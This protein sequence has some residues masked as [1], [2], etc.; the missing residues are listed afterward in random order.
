MVLCFALSGCAVADKNMGK[1]GGVAIGAGTGAV[2][3]KELGDDSGMVIGAILGAGVG[4]IIGDYIDKRRAEQK[5]IAQKYDVKINFDDIKYDGKYLG[6]KV[7]STNENQFDVGKSTLN[8]NAKEYYENLAKSYAKNTKETKILI[9]GHTDDSGSS[10]LNKKLSEERAKE[11]G[12]VFSKNGIKSKN[13]YYWGAG[14]SQPIADNNKNAGRMKNRRVEIIE[15]SNQSDIVKYTQNIKVNPAYFTKLKPAVIAKSKPFSK[16]KQRQEPITNKKDN[17][18]QVGD[19]KE[20][21]KKNDTKNITTSPS[22][23]VD[24]GGKATNDT[25]FALGKEYGGRKTGFSLIAKAYASDFMSNCAYDQYHEE[26]NI[27][28]LLSGKT[29]IKTTDQKKGLNGGVWY[30]DLNNNR[31]GIGPVSVLSKNLKPAKNPNIYIYEKY[32]SGSNAKS[33]YILNTNVNTYAGENGLL[34][35]VFI[36][37]EKSPINCM[38]I[39]FDN[40][41]LKNSYGY[42]YYSDS[43]ARLF[44]K[45]F[46]IN[47]LRK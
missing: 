14:E 46:K 35:R 5:K 16:L 13:L 34:Y 11:V 39:V 28:S 1:M 21:S 22:F 20:I 47:S 43:N 18:V 12:K 25:Y 10:S 19:I 9:V 36:N 45:K 37:G 26:G 44:E 3:G 38:D 40:F 31:V 24:F 4:L 32:I 30:A 15:L 8:L 27:K 29:I 23:L 2:I 6:D 33:N 42:L 17:S 7:V 41:D